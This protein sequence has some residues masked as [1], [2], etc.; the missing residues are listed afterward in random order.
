MNFKHLPVF[1]PEEALEVK[2]NPEFVICHLKSASRGKSTAG[3]DPRRSAS[4]W[5][6]PSPEVEVTVAITVEVTVTDQT[7]IIRASEL[8]S[9]N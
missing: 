1:Y 4:R 8:P 5:S 3:S 2:D 7:L 6:T 9:V